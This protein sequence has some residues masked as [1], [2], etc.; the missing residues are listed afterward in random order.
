V[1]AFSP[2]IR[3]AD[4]VVDVEVVADFNPG[5]PSVPRCVSVL[6]S[7]S[8]LKA[9]EMSERPIALTALLRALYP[10]EPGST[11]A[12][13]RKATRGHSSHQNAR[14]LPRNFS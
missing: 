1:G 3:P 10:R 9:A 7:H 6:T 8:L 4:Q 11:V 2:E 5:P 14:R 12:H 13:A